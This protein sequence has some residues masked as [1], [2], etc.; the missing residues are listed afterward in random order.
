MTGDVL[1]GCAIGI[2]TGLHLDLIHDMALRL[3]ALCG[4]S[5]ARIV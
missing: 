3:L 4:G 5:S 1:L 2:I